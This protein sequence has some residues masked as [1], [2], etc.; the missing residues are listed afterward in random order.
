MK[1]FIKSKITL[2]MTGIFHKALYFK[3]VLSY[4]YALGLSNPVS[5]K[6]LL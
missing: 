2:W 4:F 5:S 3:L 6:I 1:I